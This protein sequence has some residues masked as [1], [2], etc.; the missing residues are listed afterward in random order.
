MKMW[1]S[2]GMVFGLLGCASSAQIASQE[3]KVEAQR[4]QLASLDLRTREVESRLNNDRLFQLL[5]EVEQ[6]K[7]ELAQLRGQFDVQAHTLTSLQK[8][9]TDLFSD[10]DARLATL[11]KAA[12]SSTTQVSPTASTST[13]VQAFPEKYSAALDLLR[14]RKFSEAIQALST[15]SKHSPPNA[16]SI[17]AHYW[18]GV[19]LM[20]EKKWR[21]AV[22]ALETFIKLDTEHARVPEA[23]R[24]IG[25]NYHQLGDAKA[26]NA[27]WDRLLRRF[28]KSDAAAKV[29]AARGG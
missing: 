17:E 2:L 26:G 22:L 8:R 7:Q 27:M 4:Q 3:Q 1:I 14:A 5:N 24:A 28:P 23:M 13:S 21:P 25:S 9:Q 20:S 29:R 15:L 16:Q 18:L 10:A 6:M 12:N 11:E 19:A